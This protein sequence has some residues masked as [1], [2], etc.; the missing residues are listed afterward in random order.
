MPKEMVIDTEKLIC[1][2]ICQYIFVMFYGLV[3]ENSVYLGGKESNYGY[4]AD[5]S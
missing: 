2:M 5:E 1:V 3:V 4:V